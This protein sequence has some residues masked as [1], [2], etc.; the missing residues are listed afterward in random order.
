MQL[1][2]SLVPPSFI[3]PKDFV[4]A[5][6]LPVGSSK[7]IKISFVAWPIPKI[8]WTYENTDQMPDKTRFKSA[9]DNL[10]V[11]LEMNKVKRTD[12]GV[13]NVT[14]VNE[15]GSANV[16]ITLTVL[17]V[18]GPVEDLQPEF[19]ESI[20]D[21]KL[22]WIEPKDNGGSPV[23]HYLVSLEEPSRP[24][25]PII[26]SKKITNCDFP[27]SELK[28]ETFYTASVQA[29]NSVGPGESKSIKFQTKNKVKLN[30][31]DQPTDLTATVK[32]DNGI[33]L[34]WKPP[35]VDGGS[36]ITNYVIEKCP[37]KSLSPKWTSAISDNI[38][39][40]HCDIL[41]LKPDEYSF[42]VSA[43]NKIG[44]GNPSIPTRIKLEENKD[45]PGKP[46]KP[47]LEKSMEGMILK[48]KAPTHLGTPPFKGYIIEITSK[49][50]DKWTDL[51]EFPCEDEYYPVSLEVGNDELYRIVAVNKVG[52]S[53]PSDCSDLPNYS[54][55]V[56]FVRELENIH[57]TK[58]PSDAFFE[59]ELSEPGLYLTWLKN[60]IPFTMG[61][62][63]RY[64]VH[65]KIHRLH[66][67]NLSEA[68]EAVYTACIY[69]LLSNGCLII[70]CA[71]QWNL[72]SDFQEHITVRAGRNVFLE[73]PFLA[74]PS[75]SINWS[76]NNGPVEH[77]N[78]N[79]TKETNIT[80][81]KIN[82]ATLDQ[83]GIYLCLVEND[84]GK[85][86]MSIDVK[87]LDRPDKPQSVTSSNQSPN[88]ILVKWETPLRDGGKPITGYIVEKRESDKRIWQ[89]VA[90]TDSKNLQIVAP[91][92]SRQVPYF[93]RIMAQNEIGISEPAETDRSVIL[94]PKASEF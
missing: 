83:Q 26:K 82:K 70:E 38:V 81:F 86:T 60:G 28:P 7:S 57:I 90:T 34:T 9:I 14:I 23:E 36:P 84:F 93:F 77:E 68:D 32:N 6:V 27:M 88:D 71:P 62:K 58:L 80:T 33:S 1:I 75:A 24:S 56:Y 39:D 61:P 16:E 22:K 74:C 31:P 21:V 12:A 66:F 20:T 67:K 5:I 48:W 8:N 18:P 4:K 44:V 11:C 51:N 73:L 53:I 35:K 25:T 45:L 78:V 42:R 92:L 3:L 65:E 13:Y 89:H 50:N 63:L 19:T 43:E 72:P 87:V 64:D 30:V 10:C 79:V 69:N 40:N 91:N 76:F 2:L 17:D 52:K 54:K 94:P 15:I 41:N 59:C 55:S 37:T 47:Y 85:C 29:V 49:S 46:G